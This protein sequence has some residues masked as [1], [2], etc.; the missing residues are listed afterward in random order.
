MKKTFS[1]SWKSSKKPRKQ[2]KYGIKAPLHIKGK[3][4][5]ATLSKELRKKYGKRSFR[6]KKGD[7]IKIMRGNFRK[8]EGTIEKVDIKKGIVNIIKMETEKKE[9]SK[10]PRPIRPSNI[11][12]IELNIDDKKRKE[13]LERK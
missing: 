1:T 13:K 2:R 4:L 3:F 5:N 7:K 8:K 12:I 10:I 9:G 6:V 11:M